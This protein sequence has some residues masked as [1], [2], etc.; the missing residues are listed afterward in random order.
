L[1]FGTCNNA[2]CGAVWLGGCEE[3][4]PCHLPP[5]EINWKAHGFPKQK[6]S[7]PPLEEEECPSI[8]SFKKKKKKKEKRKESRINENIFSLGVILQ[9]HL[10]KLSRR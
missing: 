9:A 1:L 2:F 3:D 4:T 7:Y 6:Q 5:W 10:G 8:L